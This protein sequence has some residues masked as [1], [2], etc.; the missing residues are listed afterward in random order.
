MEDLPATG[1]SLVL[2]N[3]PDYLAPSLCAASL[4]DSPENKGS[5]PGA[6][7]GAAQTGVAAPGAARPY[8]DSAPVTR[9]ASVRGVA[10]WE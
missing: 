5:S 3:C 10:H 8:P 2:C 4:G 9:P 7:K 6:L 1:D